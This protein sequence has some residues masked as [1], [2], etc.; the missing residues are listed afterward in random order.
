MT[1]L[2]RGGG[3]VASRT[4]QSGFPSQ[5]G[6]AIP[7]DPSCPA[8]PALLPCAVRMSLKLGLACPTSSAGILGAGCSWILG[9][10]SA[11]LED[12][13]VLPEAGRLFGIGTDTGPTGP[14]EE[15]SKGDCTCADLAPFLPGPG[16]V[17]LFP[18]AL[19]PDLPEARPWKGARPRWKLPW[20]LPL[21]FWGGDWSTDAG[22][23][24]LPLLRLLSAALW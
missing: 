16:G 10:P 14:A 19:P 22:R 9:N 15:S 17:S 2:K 20:K 4:A 7:G 11:L 1:H 23:M 24:E 12:L 18:L 21:P 13:C 5:G 6:M 3:G 8:P